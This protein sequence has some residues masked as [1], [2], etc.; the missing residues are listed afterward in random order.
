MRCYVGQMKS[1]TDFL[2]WYEIL[3]ASGGAFCNVRAVHADGAVVVGVGFE[4]FC[5]KLIDVFLDIFPV[6]LVIQWYTLWLFLVDSGLQLMFNDDCVMVAESR[7][8]V[9]SVR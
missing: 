1:G 6:G 4:V 7:W 2:V 3:S 8:S 9:Y 5:C